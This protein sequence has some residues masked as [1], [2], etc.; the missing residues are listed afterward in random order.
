VLNG[1]SR[2]IERS[3]RGGCEVGDS[4]GASRLRRRGRLGE[5]GEANR[6]RGDVT[7]NTR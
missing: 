1:F 4:G 6:L 3:M 5:E 7:S 2:D